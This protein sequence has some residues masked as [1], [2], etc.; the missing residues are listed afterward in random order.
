MTKRRSKILITQA[1]DN[2]VPAIERHITGAF[3]KLGLKAVTKDHP[4]VRAVLKYMRDG[5]RHP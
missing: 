2:T 3:G 4:S 5:V 1:I